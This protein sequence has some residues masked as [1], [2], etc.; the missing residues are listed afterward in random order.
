MEEILSWNIYEINSEK[1][2]LQGVKFRGRIR[3]FGLLNNINVL[4][5]NVNQKD[6]ENKVRFAVLDNKDADK[7]I[8]FIKSLFP[9]I[10]VNL[11]LE[12][13]KNPV[14]SRLQ[15]NKEERYE[16]FEETI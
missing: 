14:L 1:E 9:S 3:K 11:V 16:I 7:I 5:E 13:I 4:A 2:N 6:G 10:E 12:N 8:N 15:V